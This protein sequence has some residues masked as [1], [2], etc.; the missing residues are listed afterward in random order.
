MIQDAFTRVLHLFEPRD[1]EDG[2][3]PTDFPE[4]LWE[5]DEDVWVIAT[6]LMQSYVLRYVFL[7]HT[8]I[9]KQM[10]AAGVNI[11]LY[12]ET[13]SWQGNTVPIYL[14]FDTCV[15]YRKRALQFCFFDLTDEDVQAIDQMQTRLRGDALFVKQARAVLGL[16]VAMVELRAQTHDLWGQPLP[17][18]VFEIMR[19]FIAAPPYRNPG[20]MNDLRVLSLEGNHFYTKT[21]DELDNGMSNPPQDQADEVAGT[22]ALRAFGWGMGPQ[23][24]YHVIGYD[25]NHFSLVQR[26]R[27]SIIEDAREA[28]HYVTISHAQR[29][30]LVE[31]L[32]SLTDRHEKNVLVDRQGHRLREIDFA[33][34]FKAET[35]GGEHCF[36]GYED[37]ESSGWKTLSHARA[38]WE[39]HADARFANKDNPIFSRSVL[40]EAME[41]EVAVIQVLQRLHRQEAL[42]VVTRRFAIV[43]KGLQTYPGDISLTDLENCRHMF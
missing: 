39:A 29:A 12:Q 25:G 13:I 11:R 24:A 40:L 21:S 22:A 20:N 35:P 31:Y 8:H 30:A 4:L 17:V 34:S 14:F 2:P 15:A 38:I 32:L 16:M 9:I 37:W 18:P 3:I 10:K 42:D 7:R 5:E 36:L 1:N 41:K 6:Q 28:A 27:G 19:K 33:Q 23:T 26:L 43:E